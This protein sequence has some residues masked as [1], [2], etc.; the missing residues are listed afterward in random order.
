MPLAYPLL[1]HRHDLFVKRTGRILSFVYLPRY[2]VCIPYIMIWRFF[3]FGLSNSQGIP[4]ILVCTCRFYR[5]YYFCFICFIFSFI[6][7]SANL[8][9]NRYMELFSRDLKRQGWDAVRPYFSNTEFK[10]A[11][12]YTYVLAYMFMTWCQIKKG[13]NFTISVGLSTVYRML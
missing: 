9:S 2:H 12:S 8:L 11:C 3:P 6:V 1:C 13:D 4:H 10:N 5:I 7:L